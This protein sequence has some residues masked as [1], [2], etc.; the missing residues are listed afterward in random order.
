V[1][2]Y[3]RRPQRD[4]TRTVKSAADLGFHAGRDLPEERLGDRDHRAAGLA[5][6]P[7]TMHSAGRRDDQ[8][9]R[10]DAVPG[11]LDQKLAGPGAKQHELMQALMD[12]RRTFQ[13]AC[14]ADP[15]SPRHG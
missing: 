13:L 11:I 14:R 3:I 12:M 7:K 6:E 2:R 1:I 4:R 5:R 9:R 8:N 10:F 15:R